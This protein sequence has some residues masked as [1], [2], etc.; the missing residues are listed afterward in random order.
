MKHV[1]KLDR[2]DLLCAIEDYVV[3][4][5]GCTPVKQ[6]YYPWVK[7]EKG[8]IEIGTQREPESIETIVGAECTVDC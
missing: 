7:F 5:T 1:I 8:E 3:K 2:N 4:K 6:S